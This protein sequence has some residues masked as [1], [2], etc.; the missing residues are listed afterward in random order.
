MLVLRRTVRYLRFLVMPV[1]TVLWGIAGLLVLFNVALFRWGSAG[2]WL[3]IVL[4][5][6][7]MRFAMAG[8]FALIMPDDEDDD[9]PNEEDIEPAAAPVDRDAVILSFPHAAT[10]SIVSV[11]ADE[12]DD[13][14]RG[15]RGHDASERRTSAPGLDA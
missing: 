1:V 6:A 8:V 14:N 3:V 11:S 4:M 2:Q 15:G 13:D 12:E 10:L 7:V 5:L 9:W